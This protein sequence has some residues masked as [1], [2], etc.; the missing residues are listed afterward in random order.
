MKNCPY[1]KAPGK[2]YFKISSRTYNRCS[3]CDLIYKESQDSYDKVV[4]HYRNDY[5]EQY[6]A[7]QMGG[8]R[9]RL[10]DKILGLIEKRSGTGRLLDIGAGCGVFLVAA[11]KR[12]WEVKGIEPSIQS[13]EVAQGQYGLDIYNGTLQEYD[14]NG[15]FDVI[16]FINVLDHSVEPWKEIDKASLLLKSG[17]ILYLRFPNGLFHS[18]LF[19]VSKKLNIE[20][21]IA[22]FLVFHECCFT[23]RF[24]RRLLSDY[25]FGNIEVYNASLSGGSLIS[26]F[27]LFS[28][29]TRSIEIMG[30][31]TDLVSGGR[32]LWG[33]SLEVVARK[34]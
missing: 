18:F 26:S 11:Q 7:D 16:T 3:G 12:G 4:A 27:P 32:V 8:K 19:K 28:F 13:V 23:P 2:F 9:D 1:C 17:G 14:E 21:T 29:I 15:K 24:I 34:R 5:F 33:P 30:K 6:S 22:K 10:F 25:G 20:Q 31:L